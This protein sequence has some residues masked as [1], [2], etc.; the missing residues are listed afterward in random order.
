[1][2]FLRLL[3]CFFLIS[4]LE[5]KMIRT[6]QLE[7]ILPY[8]DSTSWV[9]F[10]LDDTLMESETQFGR[11]SWYEYELHLLEAKGWTRTQAEER[12][13]SHWLLSQL[14]CPIRTPELTTKNTFVQLQKKAQF[15][16]GF[17]TR[18]AASAALTLEQ[19]QKL[20]LDFSN[21]APK[22]PTPTPSWPKRLLYRGGILF[23]D[24]ESLISFSFRLFWDVFKEHPKR[25][26]YID[27]NGA[28]IKALQQTFSKQ[29]IEFIGVHYTK[30]HERPFDKTIAEFQK[31]QLPELL[32]DIEAQ[33]KIAQL[34]DE[35]RHTLP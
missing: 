17:T 11:T 15:T 7:S 3:L 21:Y 23:A 2:M 6:S 22:L 20:G 25:L 29:P 13:Y 12:F 30:T 19:L 16:L 32:S 27:E 9:V 18:P 4:T 8:I 24:S 35:L 33:Q 1:M 28:R 14:I 34:H 26:I 31:Q 10:Y 5:A